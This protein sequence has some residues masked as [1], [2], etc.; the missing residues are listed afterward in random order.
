MLPAGSRNV[1]T[2]RSPSGVDRAHDFTT[3]GFDLADDGIDAAHVDVREDA[4]AGA[5]REGRHEGADEITA[6]IFKAALCGDS[7]PG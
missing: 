3:A 7:T 2:Q 4:V 1:A 5:G 6:R